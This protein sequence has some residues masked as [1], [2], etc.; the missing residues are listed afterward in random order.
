[1]DRFIEQKCVAIIAGEASGDL[2]GASLISELKSID[3]N[4]NIIGI[5]GDRMISAGM[6]AIYHIKDMAFLGFTEVVKHI[7]FIK[8]VQKSLLEIIKNKNI[9]TVVLIDYPGFNIRVA[10]KAKAREGSGIYHRTV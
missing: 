7:P 9:T 1:M 2:H 10:R 5:G 3:P 6:N 8:K 4:L